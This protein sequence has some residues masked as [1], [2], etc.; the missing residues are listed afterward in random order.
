MSYEDVSI[1][2]V[3]RLLHRLSVF[4][5]DAPLYHMLTNDPTVYLAKR[6]AS[7]PSSFHRIIAT[8]TKLFCRFRSALADSVLNSYK[9]KALIC[10]QSRVQGVSDARLINDALG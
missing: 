6:R 8:F 2:P 7:L 10:S 9:D 1:L 3:F 5:L 4:R